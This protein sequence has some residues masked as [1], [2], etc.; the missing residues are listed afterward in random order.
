MAAILQTAGPVSTH[1][2][3]KCNWKHLN[4]TAQDFK[5]A[6]TE[7]DHLG[8]GS[9]ITTAGQGG[10]GV[11]SKAFVKNEPQHVQEALEANLDLCSPDVYSKRYHCRPSK[12]INWK[13][14]SYL[15]SKGLVSQK[16]FL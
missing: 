16:K 12:I 7:L 3:I 10:C 15:V 6:A 2:A 11:G 9:F 1:Q 14:R 8:F 5:E 13:I 4:V